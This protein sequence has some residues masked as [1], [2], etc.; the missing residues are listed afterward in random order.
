M[1][2]LKKDLGDI[3][4]VCRAL[5][6]PTL[7]ER[8]QEE[9]GASNQVE[10]LPDTL[11]RDRGRP[12]IPD[13]L[14]DL[15]RLERALFSAGMAEVP[16]Q[17][18]SLCLNP[19]VR[20]V[21]IA[22]KNLPCYFN[23]TQERDLPL[24]EPGNEV[25]VVWKN[26]GSV[27]VQVRTATKQDLLALKM[28][29]EGISPGEAAAAAN[30]QLS[31]VH[32][33]LDAA[34]RDGILLAPASKIQR[35]LLYCRT[36]G[37]R[38]PDFFS[39]SVFTLQWHITQDCD[40]H[41]KHCY[42]RSERKPLGLASARKILED[43][44]LFC[45]SKHVRGQISFSGGNPL[46]Y[47][48]VKE[49]YREASERGF[50]LAILGNPAP[51]EQINSLISIEKPAFFQVSLEGL[52]EHNDRIR[53]AGHFE[54]TMKFLHILRDLKIYS[55]VM[56]TLTQDNM[57]QVIPLCEFLRDQA[58]LFTFNRLAL[59][60]EGANLNLPSPGEYATFLENYIAASQTN[61]VMGLK[62]NLMNIIFHEKGMKLFGGCTGYGCGA[63]FN[64][65]SVLSDGEV[66]ACR[67]FPS[68]VGNIFHNSLIEIY[69]SE[70]AQRYRQRSEDCILCPI[71][72]V[73]GGC[74]AV[75]HGHGLDIFKERDPYCFIRR[76]TSRYS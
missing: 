36:E 33:A 40:L 42:D 37:S 50:A 35:N 1:G 46:L 69:D 8:I 32:A 68:Q 23:P 26:P 13:Y 39:A 72:H 55:M 75:T 29:A 63:A 10:A 17:V 5:L 76:D 25:V 54:R 21:Q 70:A 49:L 22:W 45:E 51:R 7:W 60:G 47:P 6:G 27:E 58:D 59:V 3:Y 24:P 38:S 74:P 43:L 11:S 15:A 4:P 34:A 44:S 66:H 14:P 48:H 61:P 64:F 18:E 12:E 31:I 56:L 65:I 73:C 19:T 67:K 16:S 28:V 57:S 52:E 30:V 9:I 41:C 62:D 71:Q 20:L 2:A 53:G